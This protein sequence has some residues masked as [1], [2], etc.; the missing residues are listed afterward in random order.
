MN[1]LIMIGIFLGAGVIIT[2][3]Y[4]FPLPQWLAV[5]LYSIAVIAIIAGMIQSRKTV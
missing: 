1:I 4:I 2:D 5:V 3:R